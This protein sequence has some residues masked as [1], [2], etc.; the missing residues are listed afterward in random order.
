MILLPLII[1]SANVSAFIS[2]FLPLIFRILRIIPTQ[3]HVFVSHEPY[4]LQHLLRSCPHCLIS[5]H[6]SDTLLPPLPQEYLRQCP[7]APLKQSSTKQWSC[8]NRRINHKIT[9]DIVINH[10]DCI[11]TKQSCQIC[12]K[13]PCNGLFFH[14]FRNPSSHKCTHCKSD[15]ISK[16]GFKHIPQSAALRKKLEDQPAQAACTKVQTP[17]PVLN[18]AADLPAS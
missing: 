9:D 4:L 14:M 11:D 1:S 18:Q 12:Q 3:I 8:R 6:R 7:P 16:T 10:T 13:V 15:D 2:F 5:K 17:F